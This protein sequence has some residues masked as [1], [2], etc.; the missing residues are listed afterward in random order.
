MPARSCASTRSRVSQPSQGAEVEGVDA[1]A[2]AWSDGEGLD[3]ERA[4][5]RFVLVL[6]VAEDEHL[7]AEV[8]HQGGEVLGV[9]RLAAAG[10]AERDHV[11]VGDRDRVIE[12]PTERVGV[13]AAPGEFVD[14]YLGA[15]RRQGRVR[16]ERPPGRC[17]VAGHPVLDDRRP[18]GAPSPAWAPLAVARRRVEQV[19]LLAGPLGFGSGGQL[20][21]EVGQ[22]L[23]GGPAAGRRP[24]SS[25]FR[26]SPRPSGRVAAA[27]PASWARSRRRGAKPARRMDASRR[28]P[29]SATRMVLATVTHA[30]A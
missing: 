24:H 20:V 4:A 25:A 17:L 30:T 19:R 27:K 13:E 28:R 22:Q 23:G 3:A 6:R 21:A 5:Q 11:G 16:D 7:V 29:N 1:G 14:A 18:R 2:H 8:H 9:G 12:H 10:L 15:G 26:V